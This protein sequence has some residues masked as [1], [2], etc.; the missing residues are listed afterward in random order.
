MAK[1]IPT[2]TWSKISY[3]AIKLSQQM[4]ARAQIDIQATWG[5]ETE[6]SLLERMSYEQF[7]Q[8]LTKADETEESA[9]QFRQQLAD[10]LLPII[11]QAMMPPQP[12]EQPEPGQ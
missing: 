8:M 12:G 10:A 11:Q 6:Q 4:M 5:V 3:D 7:M 2:G 1:G 9:K